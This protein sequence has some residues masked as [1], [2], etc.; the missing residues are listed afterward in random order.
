MSVK[1]ALWDGKTATP[2]LQQAATLKSCRANQFVAIARLSLGVPD[3][4]SDWALELADHPKFPPLRND[5]LAPL[6][7]FPADPVLQQTAERLFASPTS[8][9]SPTLKWDEV[10]SPLL[11]IPMFRQAVLS[12]LEDSS[13]VGKARRTIEGRLSFSFANGG[14]GSDAPG[15]D[16]RQAPPGQE[17]PVRVMD[18]VAWE[19]S[20]LEGAPEFG[21]D[22]S[23]TD[24]DSAI[25]AIAQFLRAH[26]NQVRAFPMHLQDTNCPGQQVYLSR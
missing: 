22:W 8:S 4:A 19:L 12:A 26:E 10:N 11:A 24:K 16:P 6:W 15:N 9:W 14:G 2:V 20:N 13:V 23:N 7:M 5:E 1:A 3:A 25:S 18:F 17:R 21:L